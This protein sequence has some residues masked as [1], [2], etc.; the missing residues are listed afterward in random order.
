[1]L[2]LNHPETR[3]MVETVQA[4]SRLAAAIQNELTAAALTKDDRSPV[5]VADFAVQALVGRALASAF[6]NDPL[7][8]EEDSTALQAPDAQATL[9]KVT[10]FVGDQIGGAAPDE[11]SAWIDHNRSE[12]A[13][14]FWTLD[15]I[16]GTKG[17]LRGDQYVIALALIEDGQVVTGALGCPE[18]SL[19]LLHGDNDAAPP[20]KGLLAIA[21]R[22]QGAWAAPLQIAGDPRS[23]EPLGV[24]PR[25]NPR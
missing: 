19:N 18:L 25:E 12:Y 16:D 22:G 7:I 6:P 14:R 15:P 5:T 11:V 3:F 20:H 9:Q 21:R 4:L 10:R 2:D 17:F 23:Y 13:P 1:M 8:A 24:S